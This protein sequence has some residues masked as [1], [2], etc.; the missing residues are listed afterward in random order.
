MLLTGT[1]RHAPPRQQP[2]VA[3]AE[4]DRLVHHRWM[5]IPLRLTTFLLDCHHHRCGDLSVTCCSEILAV[6]V[7]VTT[8]K[9]LSLFAR[10]VHN[11][12]GGSVQPNNLVS[13]LKFTQSIGSQEE[14]MTSQSST[15]SQSPHKRCLAYKYILQLVFLHQQCSILVFT[16][17]QGRNH[18]AC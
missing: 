11:S 4:E 9:S 16:V 10:L 7:S 6:T 18:S 17:L 15:P 14:R 13:A 1:G 5:C 3:T 12:S 2:T 8:N